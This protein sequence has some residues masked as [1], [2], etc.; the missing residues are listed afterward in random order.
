MDFSTPG[1]PV[2][3]HLPVLTQTHVHWVGDAISSFVAPVLL[4]PSI[5]TSVR[6]FLMSWLFTSGGQRIGASTSASVISNEYWFPLELSSLTFLLSKGLPEVFSST[7]VWKH[8][9][10]GAQSLMV[11]LS[12]SYMITVKITAL[13]IH[14]FFAKWYL[15]FLIHCLGL[16]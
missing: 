6:S 16:S 1:F 7:T 10:F 5:F 2:P 8:Q 13:T 12:H 15:S 9:C 4:L 3:H 14:T 11:H